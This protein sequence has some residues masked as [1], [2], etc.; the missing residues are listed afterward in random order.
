M[1][2]LVDQETRW[3][4]E[5]ANLLGLEA[6]AAAERAADGEGSGS[7]GGSDSSSSSSSSSNGAGQAVAAGAPLYAPASWAPGSA[8]APQQQQGE[9]PAAVDPQGNVLDGNTEA[10]AYE[11]DTAEAAASG[12]GSDA[13]GSDS[14]AT[15][16]AP[17]T[18]AALE[19]DA[20]GKVDSPWAAVSACCMRPGAWLHR[21][22]LVVAARCPACPAL[23][24]PAALAMLCRPPCCV[25]V[26]LSELHRHQHSFPRPQEIEA[27]DEEAAG[28]QEATR[29]L[30]AEL[31]SIHD[32]QLLVL[33]GAWVGLLATACIFGD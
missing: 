15:Y 29:Q 13:P 3:L 7:S 1:R 16:G 30:D 8:P 25:S 4:H 28:R 11:E 18:A 27:L 20:E 26:G 2:E 5:Q 21:A 23:P 22:L 19:A 9:E 31:A 6:A 17:R 10:A 32:S 33:A 12:G 14:V 24:A